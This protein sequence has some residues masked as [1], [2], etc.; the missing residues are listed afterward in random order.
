MRA[1][2]DL[3]EPKVGRVPVWSKFGGTETNW[4]SGFRSARSSSVQL[5]RLKEGRRA[6]YAEYTTQ[7]QRASRLVMNLAESEERKREERRKE[8]IDRLGR[9]NVTVR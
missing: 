4:S 2:I 6:K 5:G 8:E 3:S 1:N 9:G 7:K